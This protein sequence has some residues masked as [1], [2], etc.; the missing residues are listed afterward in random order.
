MPYKPTIYAIEEMLKVIDLYYRTIENHNEY[1]HNFRYRMY[2]L[3]LIE[4]S[5]KTG[6]LF[7]SCYEFSPL[8]L[9][10]LR[11]VPIWILGV[12]NKPIYI[13]Q[14]LNTPLDVWAH[15]VQHNRRTQQETD[16]YYD[17]IVKHSKYYSNRSPFGLVSIDSFYE[18]MHYITFKKIV[19][20]LQILPTDT[21]DEAGI[22]NLCKMIVFEIVH[23]KA[24]PV[25]IFSLIRNI[26]LGY[27]IYPIE[28]LL[29]NKQIKIDFDSFSDPTTLANLHFKLIS[30]FYD[31]IKLNSNKIS[32][33]IVPE[34]YRKS[35]YILEAT[36][37]II[38]LFSTE[39]IIDDTL[40]KLIND[41][42]NADEYQEHLKKL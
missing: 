29:V 26:K 42:T 15:D 18:Y 21:E 23:E 30:G 36:K 27:D 8:D 22:K 19:P 1:Y 31:D 28:T 34:K 16:R 10:K 38:K 33:F 5:G 41:K 6:F 39:N 20:F 9:I 35:E 24:W 14:Y 7:P 13:D 2:L 4:Q 17:C 3:H 40:L 25:T 11:C 32:S 12:T 37:R